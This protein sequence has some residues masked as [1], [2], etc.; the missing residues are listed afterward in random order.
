MG[1]I[2]PRWGALSDQT[3]HGPDEE[4]LCPGCG[5]GLLGVDDFETFR[6]CP[7]C[8]RHFPLPALERLHLLVDADTFLETNG[9]LVSI[10][11]LIFR[12]LLPFPERAA[13]IPE[14]TRVGPG[15]GLGEAVIT[16]TGAIGG[17]QVVLL[18][19][20]HTYLGGNIGPLAAEKVVLTMELA[21]T[22]RLPLI[23]LCAASY[24]GYPAGD[25][26]RMRAGLI[27][28]A[29]WPKIAAAAARLHGAAVPLVSV[30]AHPTTGGVYAGLGAQ[31]DIMVAEPGAQIG[32]SAGG[33]GFPGAE[34]T[35]AEDL[36]ATGQID[37]VVDRRQVRATISTLLGLLAD[38]GGFV[39]PPAGEPAPPTSQPPLWEQVAL[40]THPARPTGRDLV[41]FLTTEFVELHGDR[42]GA[43]DAG[44]T[45]GLGRL[46]GRPVAIIAQNRPRPSMTP[47]RAEPDQAGPDGWRQ[48]VRL[49]RLAGHLE[50]PVVTLVDTDGGSEREPNATHGGSGLAIAEL[51][52]LSTLVPVPIVSVYIG[53]GNGLGAMALGAG[54]RRLMLQ[55]AVMSAEAMTGSEPRPPAGPVVMNP[56][57]MPPGA[58][59]GRSQMVTATECAR[60]GLVDTIVAEP[61][62]AAHA[63]PEVTAQLLGLAVARSLAELTGHGSRRLLDD[64]SRRLHA[65]GVATPAGREAARRE[66][67]ELHE[68]QRSLSRSLGDLR[69]RWSARSHS[70]PHLPRPHLPS[71]P[72]L[73]RPGQL[74]RS[75][76]GNRV[77]PELVDLAGRIADSVRTRG[78]GGREVPSL[79]D[80]PPAP[81]PRPD[82]LN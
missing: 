4:L 7:G 43:D 19:L 39:P 35:T 46:A 70:L 14:R 42:I 25:E 67:R 56:S 6:V 76:L 44:M 10:E 12:D 26:L 27:S 63:D 52:R 65:L 37:A 21:A 40:A 77:R 60:L 38:R 50:L 75:R 72:S 30:L 15:G 64:R 9:V 28:L 32:L 20:D 48:A 29:Q 16:G 49:L 62:P 34:M 74:D 61:S 66:I 57:A 71:V 13:P 8:D 68:L 23:A 18:V 17:H 82:S 41:P 78:H 53:Q 5:A 55:H 33:R 11:P 1:A 69:G 79:D 47:G 80:E 22:R 2:D 45:C 3:D 31:A 59:A 51:L 24:P 36:L 73:P 58:A 81:Q 54:D